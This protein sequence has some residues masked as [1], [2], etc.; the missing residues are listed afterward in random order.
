M[1]LVTGGTGIVGSYLLYEL[2]SRGKKIRA[3][4]RPESNM[5]IVQ[6]VFLF[7][8]DEDLTLFNSIEWIRGDTTDIFSL[9]DAMQGVEEIY[10]NAALLSFNPLHKYIMNKI[11][12]EGTKNIVDVA[13]RLPVKKLCHV[14]SVSSLDRSSKGIVDEDSWWK[15]SR[16]HSD[17]AISKYESEREVWR[18]IEEGLD[19]VIVNPS[20]ILGGAD[21]KRESGRLISTIDKTSSFY[22]GGI[23]GFVGVKDV[24]ISMI[25]LM[26]SNIKN[27]RFIINAGNM[28]YKEILTGIAANLNKKEPYI[29]IPPWA[30]EIFWRM[31]KIRC[32]FSRSKPLMTRFTA[33]SSYLQRYYSGKKITEQIDFEYTPIEDAIRGA[34]DIYIF[35]QSTKSQIPNPT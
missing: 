35:M 28:S 3:L 9:E 10:H 15:P 1:I 31:E 17:Y 23:N 8:K 7:L 5:E 24:A 19:A 14:S 25:E 16:H 29:N 20:I 4:I 2:A 12:V 26:E 27:E 21:P 33:R 11:N 6:K 22:T 34:C 18:G 30:L 32:F 13:L